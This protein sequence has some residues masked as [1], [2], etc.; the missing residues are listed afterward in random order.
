[1]GIDE[2]P[3]VPV[4]EGLA[5]QAGGWYVVNAREARWV[6][7][8]GMWRGAWLEP[9]TEP[10][11]SLG[12]NVT[13]LDP[14]NPGGRYHAESNH[15]VFFVV[16]GE[17]QLLVEGEERRL[18]QWDFFHCPPGTEHVLVGSGD[19]PAV[20]VA[21]S[22]RAP[23]ATVRYLAHELAR[24]HG[25]APAFDT[26]R[27][28]EAFDGIPPPRALPYRAGDLPDTTASTSSIVGSDG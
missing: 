27:P 5:V 2:K 6:G 15:E 17:V 11:P 26:G 10:W 8:E 13:V 21:A 18:R 12:F 3:P 20:V 16:A 9:E 14:G 4:R 22:A 23:D 28:E 19:R 1:M 25:A 24:R 7:Q